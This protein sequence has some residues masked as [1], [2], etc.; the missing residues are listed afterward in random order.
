M[1]TEPSSLDVYNKIPRKFSFGRTKPTV[2]DVEGLLEKMKA[3]LVIGSYSPLLDASINECI[4]YCSNHRIATIKFDASNYYLT[5]MRRRSVL[6]TFDAWQLPILLSDYMDGTL[7]ANTIEKLLP[8]FGGNYVPKDSEPRHLLQAFKAIDTLIVEVRQKMY[9][10]MP[11]NSV[12]TKS[13]IPEDFVV[14]ELVKQEIAGKVKTLMMEAEEEKKTIISQARVQ[15]ESEA[16]EIVESAHRQGESEKQS[17]L[18]AA[19]EQADKT[20]HN[21]SIIADK[22]IAE[23][24]KRILDLSANK[25]LSEYAT[26]HGNTEQC[27]SA[28]RDALVKANESIKLLEDSVSESITRKA[29]TQLIE[30]YNLV[31][32]TKD[33]TFSLALQTNS[34][35]LKNAAYNMDVF[36]DMLVEYLADYG[37]QT[38]ASFQGDTFSAKHHTLGKTGVQ[39]DPR[40]ARISR[41][42]RNG[43]IWGEQVLQKERVEIEGDKHVSRY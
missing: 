15:A 37:V 38:I 11:N 17:I 33:S 36:L 18:D 40:N 9:T 10:G 21:A 12:N 30:L 25:R 5:E 35:D 2:K 7:S 28:V 8:Y 16:R 29:Y 26:E 1:R 14:T 42:L 41:S 24:K 23:A 13:V 22:K 3:E 27:F 43:F 20:I 4:Y 31:T 32:D 34:Q 19:Q 6:P 39:F